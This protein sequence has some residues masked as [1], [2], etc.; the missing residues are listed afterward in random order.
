MVEWATVRYSTGDFWVVGL[1]TPNKK[2]FEPDLSIESA[3]DAI[4]VEGLAASATGREA[5]WPGTPKHADGARFRGCV[6]T[7]E[8]EDVREGGGFAPIA[9]A[10]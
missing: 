7:P 2:S 10:V 9:P 1:L 5:E 6:E 8:V 4:R 3:D